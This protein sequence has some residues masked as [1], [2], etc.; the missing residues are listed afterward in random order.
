MNPI[1]DRQNILLNDGD[2]NEGILESAAK[3]GRELPA[4]EVAIGT[5]E[6]I[7]WDESSGA[8]GRRVPEMPVENE[9]SI[10]EQLVEA[11]NEQAD[12]EQRA[13]ALF[14]VRSNLN[15]TLNDTDR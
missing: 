12:H 2:L 9:K 11:G 4:P 15:S 3:I 8:T 13:A 5:A 7:S 14:D 1:A 10:S 6:I